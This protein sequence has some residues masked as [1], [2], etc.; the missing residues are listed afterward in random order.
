MPKKDKPKY[1]QSYLTNYYI[2]PH[3]MVLSEEYSIPTTMPMRDGLLFEYFVFGMN[4][5]AGKIYKTPLD[6][7]KYLIGRKKPETVA[8]IKAKAEFI[9]PMFLGG[10]AFVKLRYENSHYI[11]GGEADYIG[12]VLHNGVEIECI[13]DLKFTG[14]L[15]GWSE[16]TKAS[17]FFQAIYY[18]YILY[19]STGKKLPFLYVIVDSSF[20]IPMVS[21]KL[22]RFEEDDY[23]RIKKEVDLIHFDIIRKPKVS[24]NTCIKGAYNKKCDYLQWCSHGRELIED[25]QNI[26][27]SQ[28]TGDFLS[29]E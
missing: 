13:A 20:E 18:S 16:Y 17:D 12:M 11:C 1:H 27:Y 7:S 19:K 21:K 4:P 26:D 14:N 24:Y 10:D 23:K 8:P 15:A 6:Y 2:C 28:L 29:N 9:K 25:S 5:R 3:K 22:I